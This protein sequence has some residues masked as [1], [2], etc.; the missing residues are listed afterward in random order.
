MYNLI[1]NLMVDLHVVQN[2]YLINVLKFHILAT[3]KT[4][5]DDIVAFLKDN[6]IN[7]AIFYPAPLHTQECFAYLYNLHHRFIISFLFSLSF[8]LFITIVGLPS[9]SKYEKVSSLPNFSSSNC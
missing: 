1:L 3:N 8:Y 6:Q 2:E 5:R 7:A 4:Q 9:I